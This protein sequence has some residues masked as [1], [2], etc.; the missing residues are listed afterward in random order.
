MVGPSEQRATKCGTTVYMAPEV[1]ASDSVAGRGYGK[2]A[3]VWGL[4]VVLYVML[5]CFLPF[6]VSIRVCMYGR[7]ERACICMCV[8][9]Y[10]QCENCE[11]V[12]H[13]CI[14]SCVCMCKFVFVA[15]TQMAVMIFQ[16]HGCIIIQIAAYI[17][18]DVY[19]L[20]VYE[21]IYKRMHANK[22]TFYS[23]H[24]DVQHTQKGW[25]ALYSCMHVC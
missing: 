4:G 14:S 7:S 22:L 24:T 11:L 2:E 1:A 21:N 6:E 15:V 8:R 9:T 23:T 25:D 17:H 3:D 16:R 10:L 5:A 13:V 20:C 19:L 12:Y 18:I